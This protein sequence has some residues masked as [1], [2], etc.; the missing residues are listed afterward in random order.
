[1][2][3]YL[4]A[5]NDAKVVRKL[6]CEFKSKHEKE[7]REEAE[8]GNAKVPKIL[9]II[10]DSLRVHC[11]HQDDDDSGGQLPRERWKERLS[12]VF[13]FGV[14]LLSIEQIK[15]FLD[16]L[17]SVLQID[18]IE[19]EEETITGLVEGYL[20]DASKGAP[21]TKQSVE[22]FGRLLRIIESRNEIQWHISDMSGQECKESI[23]KEL[24]HDLKWE[25]NSSTILSM[26]AE[27]GKLSSSD[28]EE[29]LL[30]MD[31]VFIK[32]YA[33]QRTRLNELPQIVS[34]LMAIAVKS[35]TI[36]G[37]L[38]KLLEWFRDLDHEYWS[39][40]KTAR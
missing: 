23:V 17:F 14:S 21:L 34:T 40:D 19:I 7:L 32:V 16:H 11:I 13:K 36:E 27:V 6:L 24:V 2:E 28:W 29:V 3:K 1:M 4:K 18:G 38:E 39:K 26:V 10:F 22:M 35:E 33:V 37:T 15:T 30:Q 25:S 9:S 8:K 12:Y 20:K 31:R 5:K